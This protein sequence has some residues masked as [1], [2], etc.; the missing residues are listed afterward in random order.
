VAKLIS[1]LSIT[2]AWVT[3]LKTLLD[4]GKEYSP[5][6]QKTREILNVSVEVKWGLE[7]IIIS[8]VRDLNYK[9]MVAE[10]IWIMAG[11]N[12]VDII[13]KYNSIMRTFSDDGHILSGAYGPR[14]MPQIPYIVETLR[15]P[16]S[17]QAVATIWTPSP[18]DSKDIPCTISVQWLIRKN[19]VGHRLHAIVNMRSSDAWLG[20]PYDFYTFSQITNWIGLRTGCIV[21]SVTFNLGSS[22]LY[23]KDWKSA[24]E[25]IADKKLSTQSSPDF[26][27]EK[28]LAITHKDFENMLDIPDKMFKEG[29]EP[30]IYYA[31]ILAK[32]KQQALEVLHVL[33]DK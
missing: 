30:W 25:V 33:A 29:P 19:D 17:R 22:H 15:K 13:A 5:R 6:D 2:K 8:P 4:E 1:E 9:F 11:L 12:G 21:G 20:L 23:E 14:L 3:L 27:Y 24:L 7:N 31:Q 16:D 28:Y 18:S 26:A 10:W 32:P